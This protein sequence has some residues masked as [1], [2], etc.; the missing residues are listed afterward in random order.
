VARGRDRV[1]VNLLGTRLVLRT[2]S[3]M[4]FLTGAPVL[5]CFIERTGPARF[6]VSA[7][8]PIVV[9]SDLPA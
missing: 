2:P 4:G 9:G 1:E 6:T 8:R 7:G 3:L 5:P